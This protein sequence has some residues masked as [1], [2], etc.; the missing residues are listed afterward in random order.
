MSVNLSESTKLFNSLEIKITI[1]EFDILYSS[2][3]SLLEFFNTRFEFL[4]EFS[5][6][7]LLSDCMCIPF[8]NVE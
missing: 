5:I 7:N 8:F 1:F 2:S 3:N 4:I 6:N